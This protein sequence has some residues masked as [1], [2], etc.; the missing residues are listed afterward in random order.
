MH[1]RFFFF[2]VLS[3]CEAKDSEYI[4]II[5]WEKCVVEKVHLFFAVTIN[6]RARPI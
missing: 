5:M 4:N 3:I 6:L 2:K 1:L